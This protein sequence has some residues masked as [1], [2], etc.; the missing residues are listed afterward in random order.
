MKFLKFQ[1]LVVLFFYGLL[2]MK[3][4]AQEPSISIDLGET[5]ISIERPFT[6]SV[7][8]KNSDSRPVVNFPS[9]KGFI[10]KG[11]VTSL[12]TVPFLLIEK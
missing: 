1:F 4:L 3:A 2:S 6:I 10:K 7:V 12:V 5:D 8:I 9:I 11:T